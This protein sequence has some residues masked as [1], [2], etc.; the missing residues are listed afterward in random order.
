MDLGGD[1]TLRFRVNVF[2]NGDDHFVHGNRAGILQ[3]FSFDRFL[4]LV[5]AAGTGLKDVPLAFAAVNRFELFFFVCLHGIHRN[6]IRKR[7]SN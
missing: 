7:L 3:K 4:D 5:F 6:R 1:G 2:V